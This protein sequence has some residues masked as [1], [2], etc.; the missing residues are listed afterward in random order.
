MQVDFE[1]QVIIVAHT[2]ER[3]ECHFAEIVIFRKCENFFGKLD[4]FHFTERIAAASVFYHIQCVKVPVT[5][6]E[7]QLPGL[8]ASWSRFVVL[9]RLVVKGD[10]QVF[11]QSLVEQPPCFGWNFF[12][13]GTYEDDS[14]VF[15]VCFDFYPFQRQVVYLQLVAG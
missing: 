10:D 15:T 7:N 14:V 13:R 5:V 11:L 1:I 4:V 6:V 3:A 2:A 12:I 8:N 9:E